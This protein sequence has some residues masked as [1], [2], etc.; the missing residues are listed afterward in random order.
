MSTRFAY[1]YF[2]SGDVD[3]VRDTAPRHTRHWHALELDDY[4]GGPFADLSGGLITFRAQDAAQADRAVAGDPFV[5]DDL[6]GT[7]WLKPWIPE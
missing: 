1:F 7:Y 3:R 2:M 6:L 4:I 5:Q